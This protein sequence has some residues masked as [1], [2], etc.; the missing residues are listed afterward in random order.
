[1][2]SVASV[3]RGSWN[4]LLLTQNKEMQKTRQ[5]MRPDEVILTRPVL[6]MTGGEGGGRH[7]LGS[8]VD[9]YTKE[10]KIIPIYFNLGQFCS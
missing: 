1:M 5:T 4:G 8:L 9:V 2:L 3:K 10:G 6:I 7:N